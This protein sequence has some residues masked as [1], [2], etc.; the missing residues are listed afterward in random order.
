MAEGIRVFFI[1]VFCSFLS[2]SGGKSVMSSPASV[3]V[4]PKFTAVFLSAFHRLPALRLWTRSVI[5]QC[6]SWN[7]NGVIPRNKGKLITISASLLLPIRFSQLLTGMRSPLSG[8][9]SPGFYASCPARGQDGPSKTA[10]ARRGINH[11]IIKVYR[12]RPNLHLY[13]K[14]NHCIHCSSLFSL[15]RIAEFKGYI[16]NSC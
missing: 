4:S 1:I 12:L 6:L 16:F 7:V 5:C 2:S 3:I 14:R 13:R 15:Q 11:L 9:K 10:K 8:E